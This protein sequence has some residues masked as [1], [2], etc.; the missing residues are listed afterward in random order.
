MTNHKPYGKEGLAFLMNKSRT[1]FT[2]NLASPKLNA[3]IVK[4]L[5]INFNKKYDLPP[6]LVNY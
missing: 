3:N 4:G 2:R 5:I 1:S 6:N